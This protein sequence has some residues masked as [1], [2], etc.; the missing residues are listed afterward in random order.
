MSKNDYT[1]YLAHYKTK[2]SKKGVRRYQSYEVAPNPSGYVGQEVGEAAAQSRRVGGDDEKKEDDFSKYERMSVQYKSNLQDAGSFKPKDHPV[3]TSDPKQKIESLRSS[4]K[5][6]RD[7][8]KKKH[9]KVRL[10]QIDDDDAI[11]LWYADAKDGDR[12]AKAQMKYLGFDDAAYK[13]WDKMRSNERSV[14]KQIR[15]LQKSTKKKGLFSMFKHSN[16]EDNPV[17]KRYKNVIIG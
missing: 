15:E 16:I 2:G 8:F 13:D 9:S 12:E 7:E 1:S 6:G 4:L 5:T 11:D 17:Y 3:E 14:Q 10:D